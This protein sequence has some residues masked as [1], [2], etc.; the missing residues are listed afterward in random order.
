MTMFFNGEDNLGFELIGKN[1]AD[2]CKTGFYFFADG[3]GDFVVSSGVLH[4]HE[5]PS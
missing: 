4:V 5:R 1:F 3:S 2:F